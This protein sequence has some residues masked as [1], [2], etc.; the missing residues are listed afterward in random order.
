VIWEN[1]LQEAL[2][3]TLKSKFERVTYKPI[4]M[5]CLLGTNMGQST[6]LANATTALAK[7]EIAVIATGMASGRV[8]MQF[9]VDREQFKPAIIALNKAVG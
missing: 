2:I 4:A 7:A 9:V 1:D 6:L 3:N 5:V 8:N